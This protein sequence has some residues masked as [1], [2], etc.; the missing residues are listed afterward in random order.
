MAIVTV[1]DAKNHF[2]DLLRRAEYGGERVIVE[3]H[4]RPVAVIVSTDDLKRLESLE[5]VADLRDA[6]AALKEAA[7]HGT[8]PLDAVLRKH[9]LDHLLVRPQR[10]KA[11]RGSGST[12]AARRKVRSRVAAVSKKSRR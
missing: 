6:E 9:G 11:R 12:L 10:K 5:D 4:G 3:R 2:S 1:A 8:I 7:E